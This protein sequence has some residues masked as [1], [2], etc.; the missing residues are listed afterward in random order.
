M[1][2]VTKFFRMV[3]VA[4]LFLGIS[5]FFLQVSAESKIDVN[6]ATAEQLTEIKGIGP[7]IAKRIVD[8]REENGRFTSTEQLQ[9]V[10]G[11]GSGTLA[12]IEE[13]ITLAPDSD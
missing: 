5:G 11:I 3:L 2:G 13:R 4:V 9:E 1:I 10:K 8:Y 12:K 6:T 7:V